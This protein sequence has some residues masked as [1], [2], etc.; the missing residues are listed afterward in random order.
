MKHLRKKSARKGNVKKLDLINRLETENKRLRGALTS[1]GVAQEQLTAQLREVQRPVQSLV[2]DLV[3]LRTEL[4]LKQDHI[5][6]LQSQLEYSPAH[7]LAREL[8]H[9]DTL[10]SSS[11]SSFLFLFD[12]VVCVYMCVCVCVCV[13]GHGYGCT[14]V[15]ESMQV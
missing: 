10:V 9:K 8:R 2:D 12:C 11:S 7:R 1:Q 4:S 5:L 13:C 15:C 14:Q 6:R 3:A